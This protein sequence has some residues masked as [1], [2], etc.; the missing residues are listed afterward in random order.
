MVHYHL[1]NAQ[2]LSTEAKQVVILGPGPGH[3]DD[4]LTK[5]TPLLDLISE[6]ENIFV[7]GICLG[8]QLWL[9]RLGLVLKRAQQPVHGQSLEVECL[10]RQVRVAQFYNSLCVH[11]DVEGYTLIKNSS[12]EIMTAKGPRALTYQF[13]PESVGTSYPNYFFGSVREFLYN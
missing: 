7:L 12:A 4:Y 9:R 1:L 6:R 13:H 2:L 8:H 3:P 10:D 5:M 11:G